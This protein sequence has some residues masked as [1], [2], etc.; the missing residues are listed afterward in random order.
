MTEEKETIMDDAIALY[1]Q[2]EVILEKFVWS[3]A[4]FSRK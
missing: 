1:M 3:I 2:R 4:H